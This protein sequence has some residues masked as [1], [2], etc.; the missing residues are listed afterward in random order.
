MGAP[1]AIVVGRIVVA[2]LVVAARARPR[3][4]YPDDDWGHRQ[5]L[6]GGR[7]VD[8]RPYIDDGFSAECRGVNEKAQPQRPGNLRRQGPVPDKSELAAVVSKLDGVLGA[9]KPHAAMLT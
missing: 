6:G 5:G 7:W 3:A 9:R 2:I 8:R 4:P 1:T